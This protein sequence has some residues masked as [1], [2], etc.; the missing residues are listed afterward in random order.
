MVFVST[1]YNFYKLLLPWLLLSDF[2]IW[3]LSF[4]GLGLV[5]KSRAQLNL[6]SNFFLPSFRVWPLEKATNSPCLLIE[7]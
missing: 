4:E 5:L 1:S 3:L 2:V 7:I 6:T